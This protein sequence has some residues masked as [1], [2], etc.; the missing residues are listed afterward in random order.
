M[1]GICADGLFALCRLSPWGCERKKLLGKETGRK[2]QG[3]RREG[4]GLGEAVW[5]HAAQ[6]R[7][8]WLHPPSGAL[9][10]DVLPGSRALLS[11]RKCCRV[12]LL[13][14]CLDERGPIW[15]VNF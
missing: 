9:Q 3:A 12:S 13:L 6:R 7:P 11:P 2:G 15:E 1:S 8:P 5:T 4:G 10:L 14:S